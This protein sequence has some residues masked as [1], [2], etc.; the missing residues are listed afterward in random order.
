MVMQDKLIIGRY[1]PIDSMV[2]SLD[3]RAKLTAMLIF[4][5]TVFMANNAITYGILVL[6]IGITVTLSRVPISYFIKGLRPLL[7]LILLTV[8]LQVFFTPGVNLI[9]EL[10]AIKV[11]Q[12][13]IVN[14]VFIFLRFV[15][16][17]FMSTLL[18]LT[19]KPLEIADGIEYLL[20]PLSFFN[21]P[22]HTMALM[23]SIALRFVPTLMEEVDKIMNAQRARGM[24]FNE[25]H[26]IQRMKNI[27]PL[28]IP[29]FISSF[30]RAID[31]AVAMEARGYNGEDN[32]TKYRILKWKLKD[33]MTLVVFFAL[34]VLTFYLKG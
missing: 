4:L 21:V 6:F 31:L 32:R 3:P 14:G 24:D 18:T 9:F 22:V 1:L 11:Y 10:G 25:G 28:L 20:S 15:L 23:L 33:T 13:G 7:F 16:I 29:L 34:L 30:N 19:T 5:I 8:I 26:I 17:I 12:E 2:H 27:V